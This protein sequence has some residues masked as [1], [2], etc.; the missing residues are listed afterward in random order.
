MCGIAGLLHFGRLADAPLRVKRM[1]DSMVHRGPDGEGY[2]NGPDCAL[3]FR[4]LAVVDIEGGHQPMPNED[5]TVWS[6]FNGEIYNHRELRHE[7]ELAGHRF[8]TDHSDTEVLVHGWEEWGVEL[9][10]R[11]NG[12][13]AFAI[14]D[15]RSRSM[16]LARDRLGIKPL[17]MATTA[18]GVIAFGSEVRAIHASG[19]VESRVDAAGIVEYFTL[20]N[21]WQGRTPFRDIRLLPAGC[22][23]LIGPDGRQQSTF[24]DFDFQRGAAGSAS[25]KAGEFREVLLAAVRRQLAADVPVSAYLSGGID[26]SAIAAAAHKIDPDVKAYS[27]IFDLADVGDDRIVD[28]REFS[29]AV[30]H[31]LS[32]ERFELEVPQDAVSRTL[33][34]TVHALEYPRMGM[35]YV[36][37]LIAAEA[38]KGGKVVLS[39]MGGDEMTG[40]Y[41]GRYATVP[42]GVSSDDPFGV[43]RMMLNV[44]IAA[45]EIAEAFTPELLAQAGGFD[46]LQL[47]RD[48]IDAAPS[49]DPWDVLMYVDAKT[50]LHGLLV[51]ED[52]LSMIHSLE[53]RV[54][55]LDNEVIDYLLT[56]SWPELSDG[57]TGKILFREAVRPWVPEQIYSK[58]KMGFGPPD[59]SWYR[60]RMRGWVEGQLASLAKRGVLQPGFIRRKF[61]DHVAGRS[62][63]VAL[64]WCMISFESW[65]RQTNILGDAARWAPITRSIPA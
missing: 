11:L 50:Y 37:Y 12:M 9:P 48:M 25:D 59:A 45:H 32:I 61:D 14:W 60:G 16:F 27:C 24:W 18:G 38:A 55:L 65:C 42:W 29:R 28:E 35:A 31:A 56:V 46:P 19:V 6:V 34:A 64:I 33:D 15:Q 52:K 49:H 8:R 63:N 57:K 10:R 4:R 23:E 47:I 40:G 26:S 13:F 20:M 1:A 58:P 54:P 41:V 51:L 2:W 53:T 36:N 7:L 39:G 30:A 5:E 43:Y 22:C 62:N 44:P 3:G 17:Y 21:M